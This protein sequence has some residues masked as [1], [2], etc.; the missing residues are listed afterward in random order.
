MGNVKLGS[1]QSPRVGN[2]LLS[3][4]KLGNRGIMM[5]A[6]R[7]T[8]I[9]IAAATT[10]HSANA[11]PTHFDS[12]ALILADNASLRSGYVQQAAVSTWTDASD[13]NNSGGTWVTVTMNQKTAFPTRTAVSNTF[14]WRPQFTIT[15]RIPLSSKPRTDGG[16]Y[17]IF[18]ARVTMAINP[19]QTVFG[20]MSGTN[21]TPDDITNWA[22]KPDGMFRCFRSKVGSY[23]LSPAG[24]DSMVNESQSPI[25]G[26]IFYCR[27]K[28]VNVMVPDDSRG[29]GRG[30]FLKEGYVMPACTDLNDP[31]GIAFFYMGCAWSGQVMNG[32]TGFGQRTIEMLNEA[33]LVPNIAIQGGG[34]LNDAP[35]SIP[36]TV[37]DAWRKTLEEVQAC[38][39]YWGVESL[40]LTL[41]PAGAGARPWGATSDAARLAFNDYLKGLA[42]RGWNVADVAALIKSTVL[43]AS[44]AYAGQIVPAAGEYVDEVHYGDN[45]NARIANLII[46]PFLK[47]VVGIV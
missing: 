42:A 9:A 17:P 19:Y 6:D 3:Q 23:A 43:D 35:N 2:G 44:S 39:S 11:V 31:D 24:F 13:L 29:T 18:G 5:W 1:S 34:S 25:V 8:Q 32:P 40:F 27:N 26:A 28:V 14:G 47:K 41:G 12:V 36:T 38:Y 46:K 33:D 45:L 37:T 22:T 20:D 4:G 21:S 7:M 15:D 16:R 30:T 10:F